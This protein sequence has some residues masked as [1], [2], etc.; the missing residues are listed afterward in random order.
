VV[1]R[2]IGSQLSGRNLR[3]EKGKHRLPNCLPT[4]SGTDAP[5][6]TAEDCLPAA[7]Q[8][9]TS[10]DRRWQGRGQGSNSEYLVDK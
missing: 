6:R 1:V 4:A 5:P 3:N 8:V 10:T 2:S 9:L 7:R